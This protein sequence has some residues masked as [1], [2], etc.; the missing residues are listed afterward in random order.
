MT[1]HSNVALAIRS[2]D[3]ALMQRMPLGSALVAV[4]KMIGWLSAT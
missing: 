3:G 2:S 1:S 4:W